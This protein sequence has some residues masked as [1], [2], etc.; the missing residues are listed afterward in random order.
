MPFN[1][2]AH[3]M[4]AR[5]RSPDNKDHSILGPI[6]RPSIYRNS[7]IG[8]KSKILERQVEGLRGDMSHG[9]NSLLE[10]DGIGSYRVCKFWRS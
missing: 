6:V 1:D 5:F 9:Q 3:I 2:H 10:G 7:H 4:E 8:F